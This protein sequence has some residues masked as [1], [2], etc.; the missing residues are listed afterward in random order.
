MNV[1]EM[2]DE[3][4]KRIEDL[5]NVVTELLVAEERRGDETCADAVARLVAERNRARAELQYERDKEYRR[6]LL[7]AA[8]MLE[9][10]YEVT[11][12]MLIEQA[13]AATPIL[14]E[15]AEQLRGLA[16]RDEK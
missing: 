6:G 7:R 14:I 8:D 15:I 2:L 3:I 11:S 16:E 1:Y 13:Y 9:G 4:H 5:D 12:G 10:G